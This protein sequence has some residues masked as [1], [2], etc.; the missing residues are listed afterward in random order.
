MP[1][2]R[3][4][5]TIWVTGT[6]LLLGV[7]GHSLQRHSS[8]AW[9]S[10]AGSQGLCVDI[11]LGTLG[12]QSGPLEPAPPGFRFT[13]IDYDPQPVPGYPN[14]L[15]HYDYFV[16]PF[17]EFDWFSDG[18]SR[19]LALPLWFLLFLFSALCLPSYLP[20]RRKAPRSPL[21]INEV[22]SK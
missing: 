20:A 4:I 9:A 16:G 6:V 21:P 19:S 17:G 10:P 5:L 2:H 15:Q 1:R 8:I 11:Y 18:S 3:F 13:S 22:E 12:I 7:W 14:A